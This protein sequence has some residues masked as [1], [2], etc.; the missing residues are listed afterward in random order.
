[1]NGV[2]VEI[3]FFADGVVSENELLLLVGR[4]RVN[5]AVS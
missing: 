4:R 5:A 2:G 1:M 3:M